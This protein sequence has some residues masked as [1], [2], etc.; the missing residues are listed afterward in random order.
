MRKEIALKDIETSLL[1][2]E[3][4]F[5]E[6]EYSKLKQKE[7]ILSSQV[8][9][10]LKEKDKIKKTIIALHKIVYKLG[11]QVKQEDLKS[12]EYIGYINSMIEG[13]NNY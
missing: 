5:E 1:N 10:L 8:N 13:V 4:I 12:K 6:A 7:E 9:S 3:Y 11:Y 2:K